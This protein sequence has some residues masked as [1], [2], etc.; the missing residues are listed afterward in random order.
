MLYYLSLPVLSVLFIV[1]QSMITDVVFSNRFVF[2][3]SLLVVI[4]A[5][6]RLDF[7]RGTFL[8][9]VFGLVFDCLSGSVPGIFALIYLVVFWCSFYISDWLD[10]EKIHIIIFFSFVC[11]LL[12]E[13]MIILFYYLAFD[14]NVF[15]S[16]YFVTFV[17]AL[18]IGLLA[19]LFFYVMDRTGLLLD[20]EK[21]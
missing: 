17:K 11:A 8:A 5:G 18:I 6:F 4:Y 14:V 9:L 3:L 2:E 15:I 10:T 21:V 19:P 16:F 20:E 1:L 13:M 12:K 7:I